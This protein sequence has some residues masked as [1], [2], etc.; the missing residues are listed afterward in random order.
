M[1][2]PPRHFSSRRIKEK[3]PFTE[4]SQQ[5]TLSSQETPQ[6]KAAPRF[7]EDEKSVLIDL[8]RQFKHS[9]ECKKTDVASVAKK[10]KMKRGKK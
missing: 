10:K 5:G 9:I 3:E 7:T 6:R 1:L 8:V 4:I 2:R